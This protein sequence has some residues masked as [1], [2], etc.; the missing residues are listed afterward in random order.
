MAL[1]RQLLGGWKIGCTVRKVIS[2]SPAEREVMT[3]MNLSPLLFRV[4]LCDL[5]EG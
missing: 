2:C 1:M 4:S 3:C 5:G